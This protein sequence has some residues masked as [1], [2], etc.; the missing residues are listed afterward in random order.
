ME[1]IWKTPAGAAEWVMVSN[2]GNVKKIAHE[3]IYEQGGIRRYE[4][5]PYNFYFKR[6]YA[7][8]G[9]FM[10]SLGITKILFV[11]RLVAECF[12]PNPDKKETVNHI[13]GIKSDN[14]AENLEWATIQENLS[15]SH[16]VLGSNVGLKNGRAKLTEQ[17]V[18]E[19]YKSNLTSTQLS[20][21]YGVSDAAICK[22]KNGE[23]WKS[24]TQKQ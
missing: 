23:N 21:I 18:L 9:I 3:R 6:G 4:E 15:H 19:I 22:I 7:R 2:L 17:Q 8:V 13:N 14:R 11:H 12:I 16:L 24:I 1:E 20:K 10:P 5:K